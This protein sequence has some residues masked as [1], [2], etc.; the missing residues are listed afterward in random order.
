MPKSKKSHLPVH[1][2]IA[3]LTG[4]GK[5]PESAV[6]FAGY[7]GESGKAGTVR[8]YL[9]L[10]DL[11]QFLEFDETA[12]LETSDAPENLLPDQGL[13]LWVKANSPVKACRTQVY[14]NSA[15]VVASAI[16]AGRRRFRPAWW[17]WGPPGAYRKGFSM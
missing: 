13:L 17:A 3:S 6:Q 9:T 2:L 10:N 16:A 7:I 5:E 14:K 8:L 4:G 11:S 12:V 15:R 1:P